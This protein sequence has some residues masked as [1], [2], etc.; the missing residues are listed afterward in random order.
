[1][2]QEKKVLL[3]I[4]SLVILS[5][6]IAGC[7]SKAPPDEEKMPGLVTEQ[8]GEIIVDMP[9]EMGE[10]PA[11]EPVKAQQEGEPYTEEE[12]A[13]YFKI[14]A[15][16]QCDSMLNAPGEQQTLSEIAL[17]HGMTEERV[18]EITRQLDRNLIYQEVG[19]EAVKL[20]P[21]AFAPKID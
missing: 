16:F 5:F 3:N 17:K 18:N 9:E 6:F 13:T 8:T 14:Q 12:K 1:M 11:P 10:E 2:Y 19:N 20:C 15:E 21:E 4:I 7:A